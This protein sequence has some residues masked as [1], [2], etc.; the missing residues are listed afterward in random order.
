MSDSARRQKVA[1]WVDEDHSKLLLLCQQYGIQDSPSMFYQLALALAR[2]LYPEPRKRGRKSKWTALNKAALV[3]EVEQLVSPNDQAH[4]VEW[5]C[6]QLAKR[7]PWASF[8][9]A[10]EDGTSHPDPA[11]ALRT[12]YFGFCNDKWAKASR[13][14]FK[15]YEHGNAIAKWK[16]YVIDVVR[17]PHP[18]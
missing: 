14:I 15:A 1:Q 7:E 2:E 10:K 13:D 16:N 3:V 8:I 5:A 4:G 18:K 11:E 12:V 17:N 9:E 6:K